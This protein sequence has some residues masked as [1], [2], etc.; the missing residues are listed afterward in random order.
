MPRN[1]FVDAG[2]AA[3][4][5]F[6]IGEDETPI[7][8]LAPNPIDTVNEYSGTYVGTLDFPDISDYIPVFLE[9]GSIYSISARGTVTP[10]IFITDRAGYSYL[11]TDGDDI[12]VGS[13][14]VNED[15]IFFF[16]GL[17]S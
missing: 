2:S 13:D 7:L 15:T 3:L 6:V 17:I 9:T 4:T 16:V 8:R 5:A 12:A 11:T 1:P 14:D 10:R